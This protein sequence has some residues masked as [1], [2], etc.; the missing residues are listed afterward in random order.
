MKREPVLSVDGLVKHFPVRRSTKVVHAVN[1]VSFTI[2]RGE[3]LGLVGESGS[4]K[5]TVGRCILR[6]IEPTSGHVVFNGTDLTTI[7]KSSLRKLRGAIQMVF[8]EPYESLNPRFTSRAIVEENLRLAGVTSGSERRRRV[9]EVLE[10]VRLPARVANTYPHELTGGEQQR[11]SIARA[12]STRPD[13]VVLDEP[14][15]ALDITVRG[16]IIRLLRDLQQQTGVALLFISHD[17]TAVKEISHRV[18][19]MYLG[20]I[21]EVAETDDLFSRQLHPYSLALLASVLFPDPGIPLGRVKVAG[22]IPSPVD[23][24]SGCHLHPRCPYSIEIC[25]EQW[26][27]LREVEGRRVACH[28]AEDI[29]RGAEP[30]AIDEVA[31]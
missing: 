11:L 26:P 9:S 30:R 2:G 8:Q 27:P 13:L 22:E 25:K 10:L 7:S 23:L 16:D 29:L 6:L 17:L 14:T 28:R 5:T 24:P 1:G 21:V 18:A 15:S 20:E 19:I 4:G 12:L 3:T 31:S